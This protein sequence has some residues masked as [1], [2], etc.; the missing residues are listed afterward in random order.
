M[1]YSEAMEKQQEFLLAGVIGWPVSH[2]RSPALHTF[3][4]NEYHI[5]GAYVPLAVAPENLLDTLELL[6]RIGFSGLNVT[7][8]HK[9]A[10]FAF[11]DKL[12]VA[13]RVARRI[14]AVN[15]LIFERGKIV[16]ATNTDCIG[17][18]QN[19][20]SGAPHWKPAKTR[21]LVLGAGGAARGIII[22][23][24]DA[25]VRH[26][27]IL[28]RTR[29][30]AEALAEALKDEPCEIR[31]DDWNECNV[32]LSQSNLLVNTTTLGMHGQENL[33]LNLT[34]LSKD[35][36]VT[37]IVYTPLKTKLLQDA[38]ARGLTAVDGLG[39]L[40]HQAAPGFEAWFGMK[41]QV[42]QALRTHVLMGE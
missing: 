3:W 2:S 28:N 27:T 4:L 16:N 23:L 25:G 8:P 10:V 6:P 40:L 21:A 18:I 1:R 14:G 30:K 7:V 11:A 20:I 26:I 5:K 35:A 36:I 9:E 12:G 38:A 29:A 24:I 37:D 42:S 31:V 13:D 41:P 34:D 32:D 19:L 15:T 17:F 39:M 33:N 22:G